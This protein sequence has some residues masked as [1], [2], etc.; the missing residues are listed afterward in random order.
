MSIQQV[1]QQAG[2]S[3]ATVSRAFN[4]PGQV[5]P[6]TR[7]LIERTAQRLGYVPNAS[8]RTLRSQRSRVIGVVLPTLINPVFAECLEGIAQ[9]AAAKGYAILPMTTEYSLQREEHAVQQLQASNVDGMV[10]V[11]SNPGASQ[12]LQQLASRGVPYALIYNRHPDHPCV[13]VDSEQAVADLVKHLHTLGHQRIAMVCGH[14]AASDR[15]QQRSKGFVRGM[16]QAGLTIRTV[17]EVPFIHAAAQ[18]IQA[19][20]QGP[21]RPTAL[22]C[23]N[24][25]LAIRSIRAAAQAG[26]RVPHDLSVVGFDGIAL[27]LELTP[28]LSTIAQPNAD[29]GAR[30]VGLLLESLA[31]GEPLQAHQSITLPHQWRAGESC[32]PAR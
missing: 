15:A 19:L 6:A 27:G 23:S 4:S 2:V 16:E 1:A 14:R 17:L 18:Q 30:S 10:L 31:R 22:V 12:A 26:L 29:M 32:A 28:M 24:D 7:A 8:A 3:V 25:L 5:A 21:H 13:S 11:V 20:L 9:A